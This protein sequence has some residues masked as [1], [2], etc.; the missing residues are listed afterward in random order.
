[1]LVVPDAPQGVVVARPE[2]PAPEATVA[3]TPPVLGVVVPG[4][5]DT[6]PFEESA[7]VVL[8][9]Q[10]EASHV[11]MPAKRSQLPKL[12]SIRLFIV[13]TIQ[14]VAHRGPRGPGTVGF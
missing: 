11:N 6:A 1:M 3:V 2:L 10:P 12:V 13:S 7:G 5:V 9:L 14:R 4:T 8:L